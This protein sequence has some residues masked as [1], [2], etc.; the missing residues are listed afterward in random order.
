MIAIVSYCKLSKAIVSYH[1]PICSNDSYRELSLALTIT[2]LFNILIANMLKNAIS[3][4]NNVCLGSWLSLRCFF[5]RGF[6]IPDSCTKA[7]LACRRLWR[8]LGIRAMSAWVSRVRWP[9]FQVFQ[10]FQ[11]ILLDHPIQVCLS[12]AAWDLVVNVF[13]ISL[14]M[15]KH[16][17]NES[18]NGC[19]ILPNNAH[20]RNVGLKS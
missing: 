13:T 18:T 8:V 6:P 5:Y 3:R 14:Q 9:V 19:H 1:Y 15:W 2:D 10:V 7:T 20:V 11:V 4:Q 17:D 16:F 12:K